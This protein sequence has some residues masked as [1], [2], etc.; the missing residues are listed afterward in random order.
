MSTNSHVSRRLT[1]VL[2]IVFFL[3]SL[4]LFIM[5]S[6]IGLRYSGIGDAEKMDTYMSY[7]PG[8]L[9]S[10]TAIHII[11]LVCCVVAITLAARSF[12]K[13]LLWVRVLMLMV[14]VVS[15]FIILFDIFQMM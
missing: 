11:S 13:H 14:V 10:S 12:K 5:W 4:I 1:A 8:W 9:Q 15:L 2:A 6:S 7:F 3:P